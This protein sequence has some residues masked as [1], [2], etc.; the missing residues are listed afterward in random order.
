MRAIWAQC[1]FDSWNVL[2]SHCIRPPKRTCFRGGCLQFPLLSQSPC[3]TEPSIWQSRLHW[4]EKRQC[5]INYSSPLNIIHHCHSCINICSREEAG[6]GAKITYMREKEIESKHVR[7]WSLQN[8]NE[9]SP[10][11]LEILV[12]LCNGDKTLKN[13]LK[14]WIFPKGTWWNLMCGENSLDFIAS[15][16]ILYKLMPGFRMAFHYMS[17]SAITSLQNP[18]KPHGIKNTH[19]TISL[20]HI[21]P[22]NSQYIPVEFHIVFSPIL[23]WALS[24]LY[25]LTIQY[26]AYWF[27]QCGT[28]ESKRRHWL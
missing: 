2:K 8:R 11:Y 16:H 26:G 28:K 9:A 20:R 18:K 17:F 10:L 21:S 7:D 1:L 14:M 5:F 12:G 15:F 22:A 24:V 4:Q 23:L 6:R 27:L 25:K 13:R 3:H 19:R